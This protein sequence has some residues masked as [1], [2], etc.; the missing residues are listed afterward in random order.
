MTTLEDLA[1]AAGSDFE[2]TATQLQNDPLLGTF[3]DVIVDLG[4]KLRWAAIAYGAIGVGAAWLVAVQVAVG[5]GWP[6]PYGWA[7][8]ATLL[9]PGGVGAYLGDARRRYRGV[10]TYRSSIPERVRS[11]RDRGAVIGLMSLAGVWIGWTLVAIAVFSAAVSAVLYLGGSQ[12]VAIWTLP[13]IP[14][15]ACY[16]FGFVLLRFRLIER[17]RDA[18]A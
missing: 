17:A 12:Q 7:A 1:T 16:L 8:L 2:P 4:E 6:G 18:V 3:D 15:A 14:F 11:R 5:T 13:L 9:I 10:A